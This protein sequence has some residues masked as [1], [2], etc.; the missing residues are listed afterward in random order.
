MGIKE[1]S[2]LSSF[3]LSFSSYIQHTPKRFAR[4]ASTSN[5]QILFPHTRSHSARTLKPLYTY[6]ETTKTPHIP[7]RH[8]KLAHK[9]PP[10]GSSTS[11]PYT[12]YNPRE[13]AFLF[14]IHTKWLRKL[15]TH[16]ADLTQEKRPR[17]SDS[18]H[19]TVATLPDSRKILNHG[20]RFDQ[21]PGLRRDQ[22]PPKWATLRRG[23]QSSCFESSWFV[24]R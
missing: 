4:T 12:R 16:T 17:T 9:C 3:L 23:K 20:L 8:T 11:R 5:I 24:H 21:R 19:Q 18:V 22:R 13:Q 14:S 10:L 15:P 6:I 2:S 7:S 1:S